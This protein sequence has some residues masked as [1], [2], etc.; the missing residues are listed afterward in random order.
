VTLGAASID[1]RNAQR[2]THLRSADFFD[3]D[4]HPTLSFT[5][6]T[7]EGDQKGR[8]RLT[9]DLTIRGITKPVTLDVSFEGTARDPW[10]GERRSYSATA[11]IRRSDW[12]L[13]W[14]QAMEAGG[15]LVGEDVKL[16]L[17]VQLVRGE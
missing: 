14:N 11:T 8:F 2:D 4:A 1:T 9:G 12:G 15:V 17:D 13:T 10:G 5:G 16:S 3:A 6:R 7:V